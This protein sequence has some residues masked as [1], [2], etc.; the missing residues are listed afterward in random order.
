MSTTGASQSK[1]YLVSY[2]AAILVDHIWLK[3]SMKEL[4]QPPTFFWRTY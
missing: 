4:D 3:K 1:F 2:L